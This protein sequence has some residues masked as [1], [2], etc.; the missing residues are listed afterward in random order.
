[1]KSI[2]RKILQRGFRASPVDEI[3]RTIFGARVREGLS[4]NTCVPL[5]VEQG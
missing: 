3:G 4:S 2:L 1:M 5:G